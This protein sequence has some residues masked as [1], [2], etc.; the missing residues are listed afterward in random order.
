MKKVSYRA[1]SSA[2]SVRLHAYTR[3][4]KHPKL[5]LPGWDAMV[6]AHGLG[7]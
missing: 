3:E 4:E 6:C 5:Q 2:T 7:E 1:Y